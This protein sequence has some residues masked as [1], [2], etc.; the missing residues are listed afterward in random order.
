[1]AK[2]DV[3]KTEKNELWAAL[4]ECMAFV[5]FDARLSLKEFAR[6]LGKDEAQLHRQMEGKE[7][8]Q[9]EAVL[10]VPELRHRLVIA[11]ARFADV[12]VETV[13]R[14]TQ[15]RRTA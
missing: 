3:K 13:V 9:L 7:R 6:E 11:L 10:A 12:E 4:G 14:I 15:T 1:M 2:A 8:P 5:C